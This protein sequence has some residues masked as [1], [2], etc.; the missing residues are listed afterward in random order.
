MSTDH[1]CHCDFLTITIFF[2]CASTAGLRFGAGSAV[3]VDVDADALRSARRNCQLNG[4]P[5]DLYHTDPEDDVL[6]DESCRFEDHLEASLQTKKKV[7]FY[8]IHF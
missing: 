5:V 3:G 6:R 8:V 2:S 1:T 4:L 7:C